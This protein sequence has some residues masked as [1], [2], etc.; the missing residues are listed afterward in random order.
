MRTLDNEKILYFVTPEIGEDEKKLEWVIQKAVDGGV[1]MVQ[2]R[3]KSCSD[4]K[5]LAFAKKIHPFLKRRG[6]PLLINDRVDVA[7]AAD[8]DGV[9][10]GQSDLQ[11]KYARAILGERALI[12][13]SVE[14]LEQAWDAAHQPVDYLAASPVFP[15]KTKTDCAPPW[16]LAGLKKLCAL[17]KY[18]VIAIGGMRATNVE[19]VLECGASGIAMV[20]AIFHAPCPE[21]A[22]KA[23]KNK[24]Q[25]YT[26]HGIC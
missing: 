3:D 4:Q 21:S 25:N 10:L 14:T 5:M 12:G 11:V 22:A 18:P 1:G 23:L 15:S 20:S 17:S 8:A 6:V 13:L 26:V 16:G 9:H 24:M 2:I 19:P 7:L